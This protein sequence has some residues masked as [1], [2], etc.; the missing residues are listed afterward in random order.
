MEPLNFNRRDTR[1]FGGKKF[2]PK[3][4]QIR[5]IRWTSIEYF[6]FTNA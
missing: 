3:A 1:S 2:S 6:E 5:Q 4:N